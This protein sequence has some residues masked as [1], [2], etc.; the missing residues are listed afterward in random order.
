MSLLWVNIIS[1]KEENMSV[2]SI[3]SSLSD[4]TL[5]LLLGTQSTTSTTAAGTKTATSDASS[6][7]DASN[8]DSSSAISK[9]LEALLKAL[10]SGDVA[11]AKADLAKLKDE[12]KKQDAAGSTT[13]TSASSTPSALDK[14]VAKLSDDLNAG[15]TD[16]ALGDVAGYLVRS[17]LAAGNLVNTSA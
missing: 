4:N 5:Y 10:A 8:T 1:S 14:L 2:S 17:G 16:D 11:S 3:S 13:G 7:T 12:L 15:S 9:D 6:A